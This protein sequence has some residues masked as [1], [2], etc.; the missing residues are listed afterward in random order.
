MYI[1]YS[2]A[3]VFAS[4]LATADIPSVTKS[5]HVH[6]LIVG[7]GIECQPSNRLAISLGFPQYLNVPGLIEE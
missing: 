3:F 6:Q 5:Q 1:S 4:A 7:I 2:I